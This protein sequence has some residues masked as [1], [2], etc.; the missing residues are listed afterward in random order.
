MTSPMCF[1]H[2]VYFLGLYG[3]YADP[4]ERGSLADYVQPLPR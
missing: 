4:S 2:T 3:G 1:W